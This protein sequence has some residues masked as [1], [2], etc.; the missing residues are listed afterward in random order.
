MKYNLI[1][2]IDTGSNGAI[3]HYYNKTYKSVKMTSDIKKLV[4]Y[5]NYLRTLS[6]PLIIIEKV[7]LRPDDTKDMRIFR[8]QKMIIQYNKIISALDIIGVKYIEVVP[9]VWQN[10]IAKKQT[11]THEEYK[12]RKARL[13]SVCESYIGQY[14]KVTNW[15][16]DSLLIV[17]F[18][19]KKLQFEENWI[20]KNTKNDKN[21]L[22]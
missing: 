7:F 2:G 17:L 22:L 5:I 19:L 11:S 4:E 15:N 12:D 10:Y 1:V 21:N 13:K 20:T 16:A 9:V 18:G 14:I 3:S 8:V 6:E